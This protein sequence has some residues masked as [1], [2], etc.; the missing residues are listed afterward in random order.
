MQEKFIRKTIKRIA[1]IGTG[2]AMVGATMTGAMALDLAEYPSP[3]VVGGVYDSTNVLVVGDDADAADTLGIADITSG[4]QFESKVA[5]ES[6]STSVSVTGGV[7][8]TV[9]LGLGLTNTSLF[10]TTMQDDDVENLL[11]SKYTSDL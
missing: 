4:L 7:T 5:V 2:V 10:D 11:T 1:A 3:F 8:D 6:D 9:P